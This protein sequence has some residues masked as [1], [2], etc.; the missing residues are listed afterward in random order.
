MLESNRKGQQS[1]QKSIQVRAADEHTL[2]RARNEEDYVSF[3]GH[4]SVAGE[5][6]RWQKFHPD[7]IEEKRGQRGH[8]PP[9][10][11]PLGYRQVTRK[12]FRSS[13]ISFYR[14]Q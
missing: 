8:T 6:L 11:R 5:E 4:F 12:R 7:G 3:R 1:G 14:D 9:G 13:P 2:K 10:V